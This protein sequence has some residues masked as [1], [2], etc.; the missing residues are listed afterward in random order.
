VPRQGA[1]VVVSSPTAVT[2]LIAGEPLH[3]ESGMALAAVPLSTN[4]SLTVR[5]LSIRWDGAVLGSTAT[6]RVSER[7]VARERLRVSDRFTTPFD[8]ALLERIAKERA[9]SR[10]AAQRSHKVPRLWNAPFLRPRDTRVT[11]PFGGGRRVNGVLRS[12]HYGLDLEGRRGEPVLAANRGVVALVG[13]FFYGGIS[14]YVH[15]GAGLMTTY[16]HLSRA[17]VAVGDTVQRGQVIGR[18]GATGRVTGPHLHWGAQ[19]GAIS[20]DPAD[21]LTLPAP[22]AAASPD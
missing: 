13:D 14:I 4:E 3:F 6:L 5:L 16:H 10:D 17:L 9:L 12:T 7:Q 2:G 15:H 8:S 20:F 22:P 19:Y 11:S 21:L 18:V 1:L